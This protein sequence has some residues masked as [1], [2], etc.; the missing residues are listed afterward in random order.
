MTPLETS[1]GHVVLSIQTVLN[2]KQVT[3]VP[4]AIL[5]LEPILITTQTSAN[6]AFTPAKPVS[7]N[8]SVN[9]VPNPGWSSSTKPKDNAPIAEESTPIVLAVKLI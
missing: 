6:P 2:A 4:N 8:T 7:K 1:A 9:N 3:S 5:P